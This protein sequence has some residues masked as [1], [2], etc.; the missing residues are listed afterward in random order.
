M[1]KRKR[2]ICVLLMFLLLG[3]T[4]CSNEK[5]SSEQKQTKQEQQKE[6]DVPK[7][8]DTPQK[9]D[10]PKE[11]PKETTMKTPV[12][13]EV[14]K[15][16][17]HSKKEEK[18]ELNNTYKTRSSEVNK[19]D[20]PM[21]YFDYPDNWG[22]T[23][24]EMHQDYWVEKVVLENDRGVTITYTDYTRGLGSD[25]RFM[26]Q[27]K[28]SKV[29]DSSLVPGYIGTDGETRSDLGECMV[30][31]IKTVGELSMETDTDFTK[32]DGAVYYA[33]V[34]K[35]YSGLKTAVGMAGF[36]TTCSFEYSSLYSFLAEA[37][38]GKFTEEE[39][40]EVVEI[41]ASFREEYY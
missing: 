11:T 21:F 5:A 8:T 26:Q 19:V 18:I 6:T 38:D 16:P 7:E 10:A 30:A 14:T 24:E 33:V 20:C 2:N 12:I 23:N 9:T 17:E 1:K 13:Q 40:R 25:G 41:L 15:E 22:I 35:S 37:P 4:A 31:K 39:E 29:A 3:C 27:L 34:P 28:F 32:V 36:Y